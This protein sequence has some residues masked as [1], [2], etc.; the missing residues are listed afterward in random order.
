L[1]PENHFQF[2][3]D[4]SFEARLNYYIP[5]AYVV[6]HTDT[7]TYLEKKAS[8]EVLQSMGVETK[9]LPL[10]P[11]LKA[12]VIEVVSHRVAGLFRQYIEGEYK[13]ERKK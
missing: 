12:L 9:K 3:F 7:I 8:S 6:G 4:L 11:P 13:K 2:C 5:T 10:P 1:E